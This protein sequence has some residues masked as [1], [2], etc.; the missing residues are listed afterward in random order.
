MN[1]F[2]SPVSGV[3]AADGVTIRLDSAIA[4]PAGKVSIRIAAGDPSSAGQ[5]ALPADL[6]APDGQ[7]TAR[8]A[9]YLRYQTE[10][11]KAK[12]DYTTAQTA[13]LAD[14]ARGANWPIEGVSLQNLV[15]SAFQKWVVLGHKNE[16]ERE[17]ASM[18]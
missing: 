13:D 12:Q 6:V 11:F 4:L 16:I 18:Q 1:N 3:L 7:P 8:Y 2:G 5:A 10:Y 9:A 17:L 15:D 14:P